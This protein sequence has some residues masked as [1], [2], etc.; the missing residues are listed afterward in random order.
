MTIP[1]LDP[2]RSPGLDCV[3]IGY[4]DVSFEDVVTSC[5]AIQ[6]DCGAY[7][8]IRTNS[9]PLDGRRITYMELLNRSLE[10]TRGR[11]P[12]LHVAKQDVTE[13]TVLPVYMYDF[14][15]IPYLLGQGV[16]KQ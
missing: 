6:T 1:D 2:S 7:H 4:N 15:G 11:D 9:V 5:K 3:V 14:W 16:T 13:S 12:G 10:G 8:S